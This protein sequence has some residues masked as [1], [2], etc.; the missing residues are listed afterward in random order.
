MVYNQNIRGL[1]S[2]T[3]E[4][5]VSINNTLTPYFMFNR[6]SYKGTRDLTG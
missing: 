6:T 1:P 3:D 4:L 5:S 2:K